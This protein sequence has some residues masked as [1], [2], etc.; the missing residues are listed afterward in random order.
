M[1]FIADFHIHSKYS[2]AT[3]PQMEIDSLS[4]WA[5]MKGI[6]LIGTGDFTHPG[7]LKELEKKLVP[8]GYG[9]YKNNNTHFILTAEICNN[10]YTAGKNHRI[11]NVIIAPSIEVVKKINKEFEKYG[12]LQMDGRPMLALD[13]KTMVKIVRSA[14]E[15]CVV[16]PGHI[17]TP[18]FSLFGAKTGFD[19]IEDCFE[20]EA[21]NIFCLETGLSSDPVMN[22]RLSALDRCCLISNSDSHSPKKIGREANVFDCELD[23]KE[24]FD[25]IKKKDKK[26]FLYTIEFFPEEGKYHYD[27]HRD[28]NIVFSPSETKDNK[29]LCPVCKRKLTVGVEHRVELLADRPLGFTPENSI[30]FKNFIPL[31][32]I[33][34]FALGIRKESAI[35][36]RQYRE[37]L[38][39][40]GKE[41]DILLH[42][43]EDEIM[44]KLPEKI[45]KAVISVRNGNV[46]VS[47]GYDGVY[48]TIEIL[49]YKP[50][51]TEQLTLF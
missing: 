42:W 33:V 21:K 44:K 47:P 5:E 46:K 43:T 37:I 17:W 12:D 31:E 34:A 11:H 19:R 26:R 10:F 40:S 7:W 25:V 3:S 22:W 51:E 41:F 30:P 1:F 27:G 23:Y 32:E 2:R 6:N 16:M 18:W 13:A 9:L 20:G 15:D 29:Y 39:K 28:C 8:A 48:G 45:A 4:W 49:K 35:V 38:A 24:I 36:D 50:K 14:S